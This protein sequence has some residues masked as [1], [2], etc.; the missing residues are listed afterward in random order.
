[1][2]PAPL[3]LKLSP[4]IDREEFERLSAEEQETIFLQ[5]PF[6]EKGELLIRSHDPARLTRVLSQEELYLITREM[7]IEERSEVLQHATLPQ[8]YF[9]ADME[10]WE[11][12]RI[13]R[14]GFLQ[15]LETLL[16]AGTQKALEWLLVVDYETLVTGFQEVLEV[17]KPDW[18]Y[19]SDEIL[20]DRPYFTIDDCYHLYVAEESLHIVKRTMELLFE[21]HRGRYVAL[22]EGLLAESRDLIEEEAYRKREIRLSER[23]FPDVETARRVYRRITPEEFE[24]FPKK[25]QDKGRKDEANA[26]PNYPVLWTS[27]ALFLDQ[28]LLLFKQ[29]T[30]G[31]LEGLEEE[32]A[33]LSNKVIAAEGIDFSSEA[34]ILCGVARARQMANIGLEI[35]A[36]ADLEKAKTLLQERWL[37]TIFRRAATRLWALRDRASAVI[38][39]FWQSRREAALDGLDGE[40]GFIFRGLLEEIPQCYDANVTDHVFF[41][42]DFKTLAELERTERAVLQ[43]A[44]ALA[45]LRRSW[46]KEIQGGVFDLLAAAFARSVLGLKPGA[47]ALSESA[48]RRFSKEAFE[49]HLGHRRLV[50]GVKIKFLREN[51]SVEDQALL[52][53]LWAL[54]FEEL[55]RK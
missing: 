19:A 31:V 38:R 5:S 33:W 48:G 32:L 46:K 3:A 10:C 22:M 36:G 25:N 54:V 27:Q 24:A 45:W 29:E 13:S 20:A 21:N 17:A 41:L 53:P 8:L 26:M 11:K 51:F 30:P 42:R 9:L 2:W 37:E 55:E 28:A 14:R 6:A 23:G 40:Y 18:E 43:I 49:E 47:E 15:W 35:L 7:D 4:M 39:T 34:V 12:D 52:L 1:M 16:A 50:S 44:T